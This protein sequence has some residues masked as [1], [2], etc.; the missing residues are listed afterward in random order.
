M[1][2]TTKKPAAQ[3]EPKA[4]TITPEEWAGIKQ[5]EARLAKLQDEYDEANSHAKELKKQLEAAQETLNSLIRE[6]KDPSLFKPEGKQTSEA[7]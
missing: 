6:A 1:A 4:D 7:A 5:A 3:T 2:R